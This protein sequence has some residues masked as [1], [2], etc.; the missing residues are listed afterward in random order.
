MTPADPPAGVVP[1]EVAPAEASSA[2]APAEASSAPARAGEPI[3]SPASSSLRR[4]STVQERRVAEAAVLLVM[5]FWAGNFI[6]IKSSLD[7]LPPVGF[8]FVRFVIASLILLALLRWREGGVR[9]VRAAVAPIFLLGALG[10]GLYQILWT[11]ALGE[12]RAG[13]SAVLIATTPVL[14]ALLAVVVGADTLRPIRLVGAVLSFAGVVLVVAGGGGLGLDGSLAGY[15]VTLLAAVTWA[16]Y[17]VLGVPVL[18]RVSPLRLTTW[19]TISGTLVMLP[20]GLIQLSAVDPVTLRIETGLAILYSA[21]LAAGVG[22]VLVLHGVHLL[23]PTRVTTLQTLVPA[24]AVVLAAIVLHEPITPGQVGGG[25]V[26]L[27]GVALTRR[28]S[29]PARLGGR[30]RPVADQ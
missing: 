4:A 15:L 19:A 3:S 12:I 7:V 21:T 25:G 24:L 6:V 1:S 8:T 26:I 20:L 13:D 30:L 10:F 27:L 16:T 18:R 23:G 11:T 9:L 17:T 28:Q 2:Q 5:V 14:A 22:N 29:W